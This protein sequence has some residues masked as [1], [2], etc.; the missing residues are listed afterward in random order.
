MLLRG[1]GEPEYDYLFG[2][3]VLEERELN[4]AEQAFGQASL[5][6]WERDGRRLKVPAGKRSEFLAALNGAALPLTLRN[7]V[8]EAIE[9]ASVF[10]SNEM[11]RS[12]E[13]HAKELDLAKII[14]AFPEVRSASVEYDQGERVGFSRSRP[15]SASVLVVPEGLDPLPRATIAKIKDHI[16][17]SYAGMKKEDVTVTD[18]LSSTTDSLAEEEDLLRRVQEQEEARYVRTVRNILYD[19][20]DIKVAAY[21]DIDPTMDSEQAVIKY[22]EQPVTLRE[23]ERKV[24]SQT[25]RPRNQGVP[26]VATNVTQNGPVSLE[27]NAQVSKTSEDESSSSKIAGQQWEQ[28]RRASFVTR[29]VRVSV[30]LPTT[31]YEK[32]WRMQNPGKDPKN[33]DDVVPA[34]YDA[35]IDQIKTETADTIQ[36]AVAGLLPD[37]S[38]GEEK[39]DQLVHVWDY[40]P[41]PEP[42]AEQPKTAELALS[43]LA[44]SWQ[45]LALIFLGLI[46]LWVARTVA[47]GG[48]DSAP[49]DFQEGF[50]LELPP[51]PAPAAESESERP[52][53]MTITGGSLQ[54]ELVSLVEKNPE[55]AANVIRGWVGEAA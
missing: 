6:G 1:N 54:D 12:R 29:R 23:S 50:G 25:T 20:G 53:S 17:A 51:A 11:R 34:D 16:R 8:T 48:A 42:A 22:D 31:Y 47:K 2:G 15:Q 45:T 26:G 43:W 4:I 9:K 55:V 10:E 28:S 21:A 18:V 39:F 35:Q 14:E 41:I 46:A 38:A 32:V 36:R 27:E 7:A 13:M 19:F 3:K 52:E 37:V 40:P 5:S 33:P 49:A 24:E 44:Q 30:G